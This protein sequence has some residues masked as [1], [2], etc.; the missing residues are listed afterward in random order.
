M[1]EFNK[2]VRQ[3]GPVLP[4]LFNI[5]LDEIITKRQKEYKKRNS[6]FKKSATVNDVICRR[7]SCPLS[8]TLLNI[9]L[10]KIIYK[11]QK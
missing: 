9:H 5:Y 10:D 3:G 8:P 1:D 2:G 4:T 7:P 6:T 11:K